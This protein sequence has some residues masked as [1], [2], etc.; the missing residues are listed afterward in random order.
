MELSQTELSK[1]SC[2]FQL[3]EKHCSKQARFLANANCLH[4]LTKKLS[5]NPIWIVNCIITERRCGHNPAVTWDNWHC[6]SKISR[7]VG[8]NRPC[9]VL[10][11]SWQSIV[12]K[13]VLGDIA[14]HAIA[15]FNWVYV[16]NWRSWL[17]QWTQLQKSD[18]HGK[19][20]QTFT[21]CIV[22]VHITLIF[23]LI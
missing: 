15:W 9:V 13:G 12:W 5:L 2:L 16:K 14:E 3:Q 22:Y 18:F 17:K 6:L 1:K 23:A 21:A 7:N 20:F 8:L 4:S 10:L 11:H 19:C